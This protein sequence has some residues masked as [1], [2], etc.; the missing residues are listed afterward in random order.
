MYRSLLRPLLFRL[1]P[2]KAHHFSFWALRN[3]HRLPGADAFARARFGSPPQAQTVEVGGLRFPNR[4]GLAAG[5]DKDGKLYRQL[6]HYGFGFVE[7]GTVT[8]RP[9]KGN[10]QPRL[11]RLP[12]D[13]ALI[14]RMG[15]N[16][17]GVDALAERLAG[18]KTKNLVIGGNVGKNKDTPNEAALNDYRYGLEKLHPYVDYF[19]VNVSSPNTPNL[20]ALQE[21]EPL[22]RLLSELQNLNAGFPRPRP[23]WLKIAPDLNQAQLD[24]ILALAEETQLS[25]LIATNTTIERGG[26]RSP[27]RQI[28]AIGAG[29]L[30]GVPLRQRST[31]VVAYLHRQSGGQLPI[32]AVGGIFT[33]ADAREKLAA[34]ASLLQAYTGFVYQGP[35]FARQILRGLD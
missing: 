19:A 33:A 2:E 13:Q 22:T 16:N 29:G 6:A 1:P 5:F 25:G 21:R 20:R 10:P 23:L 7:L 18:K 17:Q 31:E 28:K 11:F 32:M 12:V 24:D 27:A 9:Q 4:L 35:A 3:L 15:F 26:L 14:N 8:P 30:S 34:G